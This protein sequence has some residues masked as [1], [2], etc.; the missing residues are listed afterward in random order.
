[1]STRPCANK[2]RESIVRRL[3]VLFLFC[4]ITAPPPAA[5]A[6][7]TAIV[8][9][10]LNSQAKGELFV[11]L[12][13][14]GTILIRKTDL[15]AIGFSGPLPATVELDNE[16]HV[17]LGAV[18]GVTATYDE[19]NLSLTIVA[20]PDLL[21]KQVLDLAPKEPLRVSYPGDSS[22]FLNYG[23][24]YFAGDSLAFQSLNISNEVGIRSGAF[25]FLSDSSYARTDRDSRLVRLSSSLIHDRRR[26]LQRI[27][28]GDFFAASG[29]LG[30]S[31]NLG[32]LSISKLYRMNPYFINRPTVGVSGQVSLPSEMEIYQNGVRI[33][34]DRLAP[35]RFDIRNIT[36][37]GGASLIEVVIRDPFG[38]EQ[39]LR[40]PS[41][42]SDLLLK[43]GLHEY[44]YNIGALRRDFGT[45][46]NDY[47]EL[48]V[49]AFHRYALSDSLNLG[50][51]GEG[52][53]SVQNLG[54]Q[55]SLLIP[56]CGVF[57]VSAAAS[58]G[59]GGK[60]GFA[61]LVS[62]G[63]QGNAI[64]TRLFLKKTSRDYAT[65][66]PA[67]PLLNVHYEADAG[68]GYG[69]RGFGSLNLDYASSK[70]VDGESASTVTL[71]FS[72]N[73]TGNTYLSTSYKRILEP[74]VGHEFFVA[75]N[76]YPSD[77][78]NL[79]ATVRLNDEVRS[80][81]LQAQKN[82]PVGEGVGFRAMV[83]RSDGDT[84]S[85]SRFNPFLQYNGPHGIYSADY[86]W[87][88]VNGTQ[89]N[90]TH[91]STAGAVAYAGHSLGLIRPVTDSFALVKVGTVKG[92][93]VTLNN[94]EVARTDAAGRA[95]VPGL[96]AFTYNQ[97]G[98]NDRDIP[99]D[100]LLPAKLKII[101]PPFRSGSCAVFEAT[102][103]QALTGTIF[104]GNG[105]G[106]K[107]LE[108][109]EITMN[110]GGKPVTFQTGAGGEFY[111]DNFTVNSEQSAD[112]QE[113]GCAALEQEAAPPIPPGRYTGLVNVNGKACEF[114]V[115][116]PDTNDPIIDLG[117]IICR[118]PRS[119]P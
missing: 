20:D 7:E 60:T 48:A 56:S 101:S 98:I 94:Q 31:I 12:T 73:L 104:A 49:S 44:S 46:S 13:A 22:A 82:Q 15:Q 114:A 6:A 41:Y 72:R 61:G 81:G 105:D 113:P 99:I 109:V 112:R 79:A 76:Y 11:K 93:R 78:I 84:S 90:N 9:V 5:F 110:F 117:K 59:S 70:R 106:V 55:A 86:T 52:T 47:G 27:V 36:G 40:S 118:E 74:T 96:G 10:I 111:L 116:M 53:G 77:R 63:F 100:Y 80:E 34:T 28:A 39:R 17:P 8:T 91:L 66:D 88:D 2:G 115:E 97:I 19:K 119:S 33:R 71:S 4:F 26:E 68:I 32:G 54:P 103:L 107:P 21:P 87:L 45:S 3:I 50:F 69:S 30:A 89:I 37:Y 25:L 29:D 58:H 92:V 67:A 64:N 35:G 108:Y 38:R 85:V 14:D 75:L 43:K 62:H 18:A 1:M 83:E 51:R 65:I 57:T 24:D 102:K 42:Y 16:P 95:F 23:V